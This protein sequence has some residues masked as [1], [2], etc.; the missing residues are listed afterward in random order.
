MRVVAATQQPDCSGRSVKPIRSR[1]SFTVN[2]TTPNGHFAQRYPAL[3][4]LPFVMDA[5]PG[6]H[7]LGN[8]YLIDK[9]LALWPRL[10]RDEGGTHR[11]PASKSMESYAQW[12][13]NFLE[14]A[15]VRDISLH[16]CD[17]STHV[18]GR[19]QHEMLRGLWSRNGKGL[20]PATVNS[21]VQQ[22][23]DFLTWM[24]DRGSREAFEVPY[25]S[26]RLLVGSAFSSVGHLGI[27]VRVRKGKVRCDKHSLV[28]PSDEQVKDWLERVRQE[29]G[30]TLALMCETV[31]LT[32]MRREEVVCLRSNTLPENPKDW[33]IA[34]PLAPPAHQQVRITIRYGTKGPTYGVENGDKI[35]PSRT[36]LI[37]LSLALRWHEYRR[38]PRNL[39]FAQW[40]SGAKGADRRE[41]ARRATCLFLRERD[42]TRF[43]GKALYSIW[44]SVQWPVKGWSPHKGRHWWACSVLWRELKTHQNIRIDNETA[45]AL[46]QSTALSVI[47]LRIQPQLGHAKDS[48]TMIYLQWVMDMMGIPVSLRT[49]SE[50]DEADEAGAHDFRE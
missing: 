48:T 34:N 9:G 5:R 25:G 16:T 26:A 1:R 10:N 17:Y 14:W 47:R 35:G 8:A 21:R 38:G 11:V 7:Q 18:A 42:G 15:D 39:A 22:A 6:Y 44:T 49:D 46:L 40:M 32:A 45:V 29:A 33:H 31:L 27:K 24:E 28:M 13:T 19:Y 36:I 37:P 41:H 4:H 23:C 2:Y 12:L 43:K 3:A 30:A 20:S 50:S